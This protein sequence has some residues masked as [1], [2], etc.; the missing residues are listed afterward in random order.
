MTPFERDRLQLALYGVHSQAQRED[1]DH[2][3]AIQAD[4]T[5]RWPRV[6]E[7]IIQEAQRRGSSND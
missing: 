2:Y 4:V 7:W 3:A 5:H 1:R 6:A